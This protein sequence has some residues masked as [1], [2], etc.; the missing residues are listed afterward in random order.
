MPLSI[1]GQETSGIISFDV[2]ANWRQR[3]R[4]QASE[5][6]QDGSLSGFILADQCEHL[7]DIEFRGILNTTKISDVYFGKS[8]SPQTSFRFHHYIR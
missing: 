6:L 4:I 7:P 1:F 8:H 3:M 5:R 2:V